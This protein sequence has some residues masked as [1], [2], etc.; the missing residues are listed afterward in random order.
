MVLVRTRSPSPLE[1]C[2]LSSKIVGGA[3]N[4]TFNFGA[5]QQQLEPPS[6]SV[7]LMVLT[8]STSLP[9]STVSTVSGLA[10]IADRFK[11]GCNECLQLLSFFWKLHHHDHLRH[12]W[13][14]FDLHPGW[15]NRICNGWR[16]HWNHWTHIRDCELLYNHRSRL[17]V[18][19]PVTMGPFG[20]LFF[21]STNSSALA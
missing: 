16:W 15:C 10:T 18:H 4:D 5:Q 17:I 9:G 1:R 11:S 21:V 12:L 6:T 7:A 13:C 2:L 8:A 3:G 19:L 20:A 14:W